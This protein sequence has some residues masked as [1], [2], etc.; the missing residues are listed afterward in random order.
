MA[1]NSTFRIDYESLYYEPTVRGFDLNDQGQK[2]F[3]KTNPKTSFRY[4]GAE[5]VL[6]FE[7]VAHTISKRE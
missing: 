7:K 2:N 1:Q 4:N 6:Y 3:F 5:Y